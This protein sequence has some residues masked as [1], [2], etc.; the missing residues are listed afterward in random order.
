M[1]V[2]TQTF[3]WWLKSSKNME[4]SSKA[5]VLRLT[6]EGIINFVS[7]SDLHKNSMHNFS[8]IYKNSMP[9]VEVDATENIA[10]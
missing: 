7:R 5:S 9:D 3:K 2:T 10:A 1:P 4:L 8:N 6:H